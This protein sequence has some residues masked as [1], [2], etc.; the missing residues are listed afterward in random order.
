MGIRGSLAYILRVHANTLQTHIGINIGVQ[1][2][3][4]I[5]EYIPKLQIHQQ[6]RHKQKYNTT[7]KLGTHSQ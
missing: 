7:Y 1:Y 4:Y 6:H 2:I 5:D 3:R